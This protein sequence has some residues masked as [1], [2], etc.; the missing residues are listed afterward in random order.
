MA[1]Y[2]VGDIQG[3]LQ[4]LQRLLICANFNPQ[5][6]KL[7]V[8]GDMV[9]RGPESLKTL[10]FLYDLKDCLQV[11]LGNHDLHLLAVAA[12]F[13]KPSV[14]DTFNDILEADDRDTLIEWI[15]QQPLLHH[16][17]KLNFTMVHAGIPPIWTLADAVAYAREVEQ[18]L[19]GKKIGKFLANM[20]GNEPD[21]WSDF[22][23]L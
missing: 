5:I 6:D 13:K 11:V 10:R 22:G 9:N 2:A 23:S 21:I 14:S 1:T 15:C 3:C 7:W 12:G 20:Y 4:P 17:H 18:V 8:V 16:D 19:R